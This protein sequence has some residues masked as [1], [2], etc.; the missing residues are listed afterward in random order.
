MLFAYRQAA[1]HLEQLAVS[2][3]LAGAIWIDLY[4]PMPAQVQAVAALGVDVPTLE[5]MEEIEISNRL[6]REGGV[7]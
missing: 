3:P 1:G 4:R 5:D 2:D 6:Y 7:D